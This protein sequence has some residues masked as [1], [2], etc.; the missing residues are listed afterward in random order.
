MNL[1]R[2]I[3]RVLVLSMILSNALL[4]SFANTKEN[5][6]TKSDFI[7]LNQR[8]LNLIQ[9][10]V[11]NTSSTNMPEYIKK[12]GSSVIGE[13][14]YIIG[15]SNG[16]DSYLNTVEVYDPVL[17]TW[18]SKAKMPT[19][20]DG[21]ASSEVNGK[22]YVIG[23][24]NGSSYLN[25]VEMYNPVTDTWESKA[26]MPTARAYTTSS[27]VNGKVYVFGGYNGTFYLD[28]VE[29]YDPVTDTWETK[30]SMPNYWSAYST[31]NVVDEKI[32][33]FGGYDGYTYNDVFMY[34]PST[35]TWK[36]K[37][38]MPSIRAGATSSVADNKIYVIGGKDNDYYLNTVE[39]YDP[40]TDTWETK[41]GMP[42]HLA[43]S[44]SSSINDKIYVFGGY[45]GYH[46]NNIY[47]YKV[48]LTP[49]EK[50]EN[51]VIIAENSKNLIDI[52]NA[53]SLVN[54][55]LES[56]KKDQLQ[57]RLD[58]IFPNISIE[59]NIAT[60]NA[61][62][63]VKLEN[64]LSLGLDTNYVFFDN[65]SGVEDLEKLNIV[66]LII[67]SSLPYQIKSYMSTEIQNADKSE[68]VSKDILNIRANGELNYNT[69]VN[70]TTPVVLLDNQSS[71]DNKITGID[72]M[73][74]GGVIH[75][76]DIYKATIKFEVVQK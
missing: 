19:A 4:T 33:L 47:A 32:Y 44:I 12:A 50:A 14:I 38:S 22:I 20:R 28:V 75:K 42:N 13:K 39:V 23:G 36:T 48:F 62:I 46:C 3:V 37:T 74:K 73:L 58:K 26:K 31:S 59:K 24:Y 49:E 57:Y 63:Y 68:V 45:D 9:D 11:W 70:T 17:D 43:Y 61:D 2:S 54:S 65:Y 25:T 34:D 6:E 52:E 64:S 15:G 35:D 55:L 1:K 72:L 7:D 76:K 60:S 53:R 18:E 16:D 67:S 27:V 30:S 29:V 66:N 56:L 41:T 10:D 51:A 21:I 71:G 40:A 8:G 5:I 69:F